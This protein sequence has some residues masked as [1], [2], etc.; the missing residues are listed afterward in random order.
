[1]NQRYP[2]LMYHAIRSGAPSEATDPHLND[3]AAQPYILTEPAFRRQ[4]ELLSELTTKT[5]LS[6]Q[7][8][9]QPDPLRTAIVTF[10]DGHRSNSELALPILAGLKLSA[11]FFITTDWIGRPGY[12]AEQQLRELASA[13]ML[14]GAHGRSHRYLSDLSPAEIDN[15]LHA[16]RARLE[17]ILGIDV[18][19]MSLPG[20]RLS[21][22]VRERAA[23]AGYRY[24]FTSRIGLAS[25]AGDPLSLPRVPITNRLTADFIAKLLSG[26]D[27]EVRAMARSAR[28]R[29]LAKILLGNRLYDR[30]RLSLLGN[31]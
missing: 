7:S 24:I 22:L 2:I 5:P 11:A 28:L 31:R 14:I 8:F 16:S 30:L 26:D 6:W 1:M 21:R 25:P 29:A 27:R 4:M 10:D 15:E 19:A 13:G 12:M 17:D 20:G 3:P 18:P 23:A 9:V